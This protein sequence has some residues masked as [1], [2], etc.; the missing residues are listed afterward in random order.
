MLAGEP[1]DLLAARVVRQMAAAAV[2]RAGERLALW[3]FA[4]SGVPAA[5]AAMRWAAK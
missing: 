4:A 5:V 2:R 3:N 1:R